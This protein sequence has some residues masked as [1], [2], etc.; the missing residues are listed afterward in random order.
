MPRQ[1]SDNT[2]QI[3]FKIPEGWI[4]LADE[5]A[6]RKSNAITT[7]R[8]TDVLRAALA[9]GLARMRKGSK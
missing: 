1:P 6:G 2:F 7:T 3:A 9:D 5:I 8:R 4:E